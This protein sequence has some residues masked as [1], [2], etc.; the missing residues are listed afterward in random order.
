LKRTTKVKKNLLLNQRGFL[1]FLEKGLEMTPK[2]LEKDL[3]G[4][5]SDLKG[6]GSDPHES[7]NPRVKA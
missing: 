4:L 5:G 3:Q 6:L 1:V 2:G 7:L